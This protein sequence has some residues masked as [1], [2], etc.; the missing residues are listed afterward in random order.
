MVFLSFLVV[1]GFLLELE[2]DFFSLVLLFEGVYVV[3]VEGPEV[4]V[5]HDKLIKII[6]PPNYSCN[7]SSE[8][9]ERR[10]HS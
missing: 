1:V 7:S 3:E 5:P 8:K 10:L 4:G 2:G 6:I 9:N